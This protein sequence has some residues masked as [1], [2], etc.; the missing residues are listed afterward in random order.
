MAHDTSSGDLKRL[1][2]APLARWPP[3][4]RR[5]P[6]PGQRSPAHDPP[7][8]DHLLADVDI[9]S[10]NRCTLHHP[11]PPHPATLAPQRQQRP[12]G[13]SPP[14][15]A[16]PNRPEAH[17]N[18]PD[19]PEPTPR[20]HTPCSSH[21]PP[22][23]PLGHEPPPGPGDGAAPNRPKEPGAQP[24]PAAPAAR[25]S[26][27]TARGQEGSGPDAGTNGAAQPPAGRPGASPG[28]A[29]AAHAATAAAESGPPQP[30]GRPRSAPRWELLLGRPCRRPGNPGNSRDG[31]GRIPRG[32]AGPLPPPGGGPGAPAEIAPLGR[33]PDTWGPAGGD[34][35]T[36]CRSA[37]RLGQTRSSDGLERMATT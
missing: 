6:K 34:G 28:R 31:P 10:V 21:S 2:E 33:S 22:R 25:G 19:P 27:T 18:P 16:H 14:P 26:A 9:L 7:T 30:P 37:G 20:P 12:N 1:L 29:P 13:Q 5:D 8:P 35:H 32:A 15:P 17:H 36:G 24:G 3:A 11:S 23:G 4:A